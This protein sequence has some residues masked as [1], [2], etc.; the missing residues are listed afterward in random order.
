MVPGDTKA[1]TADQAEPFLPAQV[2]NSEAGR[3]EQYKKVRKLSLWLGALVGVLFHLSTL[4]I[5]VWLVGYFAFNT[6]SVASTVASTIAISTLVVMVFTFLSALSS[7]LQSAQPITL[8]LETRFVAGF[9]CTLVFLSTCSFDLLLS[10]ARRDGA[11]TYGMHAASLLI[12]LLGWWS[13]RAHEKGTSTR[14]KLQTIEVETGG[15]FIR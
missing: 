5:N 14:D 1:S 11:T 6:N 2:K 9:I 15:F 12:L 7:E 13:I 4:G 3:N 8:A 10:S